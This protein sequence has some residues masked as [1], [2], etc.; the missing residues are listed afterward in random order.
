MHFYKTSNLS[1]KTKQ[2]GR[3]TFIKKERPQTLSLTFL[4]LD[5]EFLPLKRTQQTCRL[6]LRV[7]HRLLGRFGA[8]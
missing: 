8:G 4:I 1:T 2:L 7:F 5:Y 3:V 6:G